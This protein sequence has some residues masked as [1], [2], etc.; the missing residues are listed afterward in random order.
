MKI[1][2]KLMGMLKDHTPESG[3]LELPADATIGDVLRLLDIENESIQAFSI[4]GS[5][6]R[7]RNRVLVEGDELTVLPPVG[8]G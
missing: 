5:I 6:D 7:D 1:Q 3:E 4:N 2:I 8:G